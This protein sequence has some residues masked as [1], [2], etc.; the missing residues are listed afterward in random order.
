MHKRWGAIWQRESL[1]LFLVGHMGAVCLHLYK[2]CMTYAQVELTMCFYARGKKKTNKN[3]HG[4]IWE[5]LQ[6]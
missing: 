2:L 6:P 4:I 3:R 1:A 5:N